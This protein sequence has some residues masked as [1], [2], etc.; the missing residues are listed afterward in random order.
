[1]FQFLMSTHFRVGAFPVLLSI[2]YYTSFCSTQ[3]FLSY[4]YQ[5]CFR[6]LRQLRVPFSRRGRHYRSVRLP[7]LLAAVWIGCIMDGT[8]W[9][10]GHRLSV[11]HLESHVGH[12]GS[13][14]AN[15]SAL[16]A[17]FL[18]GKRRIQRYKGRE[19]ERRDPHTVLNCPSSYFRSTNCS[20]GLIAKIKTGVMYV[21]M[22][23]CARVTSSWCGGE[24]Q[25]A[26][27]SRK[28]ISRGCL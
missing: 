18:L 12:R 6:L 2:L 9:V 21:C 16:L 3:C 1:M 13:R 26:S 10:V 20:T 27:F 19:K 14:I 11:E 28:P 17:M 15:P 5:N 8:S 24:V 25:T 23:A 22:R 7:M 4:P